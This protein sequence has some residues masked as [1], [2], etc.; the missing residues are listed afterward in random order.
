MN[1]QNIASRIFIEDHS[2]VK[3]KLKHLVVS[4]DAS[5]EFEDLY[6]D[7]KTKEKWEGYDFEFEDQMNAGYGIRKVPYPSMQETIS[8]ALNSTF[9]DE[10]GG[11]AALLHDYHF[12]GANVREPLLNLLEDQIHEISKERFETL[13]WRAELYDKSNLQPIM[14]KTY[15]TIKKEANFYSDTAERANKLIEKIKNRPFSLWNL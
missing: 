9:M 1:H 10:V 6:L 12:Q 5:D 8:I 13:Y 14:F 15:A 7:P 2:L 4:K 3:T 11:A